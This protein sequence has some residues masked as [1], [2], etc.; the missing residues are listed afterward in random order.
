MRKEIVWQN[1]QNGFLL[2]PVVLAITLIA[3]ISF[4][5][6]SQRVIDL[7]VTTAMTGD[8]EADE[9]V[10]AGLAHAQWMV[11]ASGCLGDLAMPPVPFGPDGAHSYTGTVDAGGVSTSQYTFNPDRDT[12]ISESSPDS[13]FGGD[14]S[15]RLNSASGGNYHPLYH[16]NLSAIPVGSRIVSAT[17]HLYITQNDSGGDLLIHP[18]TRDWG[19]YG[20]TWNSIGNGYEAKTYNRIARQSTAGVWASV[21]LTA[22]AQSWVNNSSVNH[23]ILLSTTSSNRLSLYTSREVTSDLQPYLEVTTANG[24]VSPVQISVTGSLAADALGNTVTRSV[25]QFDVPAYQPLNSVVVQ[26]ADGVKDAWVDSS[27]PSLNYGADVYLQVAESGVHRSL[28]EFR[29]TGLVPGS[30][31]VSVSLELY[32][33]TVSSPG[34]I[35]V[36][37]LIHI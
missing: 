4:L 32:A 14:T 21:N 19:E 20:A 37:S 28:L 22:L 29:L 5:L 11:N 33:S 9:V 24:D 10:R 2:L 23:G 1:R 35:Q 6:N 31:I 3:V 25:N 12:Y 36:L 34:T 26:G 7:E 16:F 18:V 15:L 8:R 17:L 27:K 13:N 30:H